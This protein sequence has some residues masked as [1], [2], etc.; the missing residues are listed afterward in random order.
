MSQMSSDKDYI[1]I[2]KNNDQACGIFCQVC[3]FLIKT[4]E[5]AQTFS[6]WKACSDCYARFIEARKKEWKDGWRPNKE[7]VESL[8][9]E[10]SRIFIQ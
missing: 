1:F 4:A 3:D 8:Y 7:D 5:D 6:E 10:K 2:K 9:S